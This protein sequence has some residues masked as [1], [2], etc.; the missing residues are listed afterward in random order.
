MHWPGQYVFACHLTNMAFK[1]ILVRPAGKYGQGSSIFALFFSTRLVGGFV[2]E[3][4]VTMQLSPA[5]KHCSQVIEPLIVMCACNQR[6]TTLVL[7]QSTAVCSE[8]Q[9]F[10]EAGVSDHKTPWTESYYLGSPGHMKTL[11]FCV[12]VRV[13][14]RACVSVCVRTRVR[15]CFKQLD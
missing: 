14:V 4:A 1:H 10:T 9:L 11:C 8:Q 12:S 15:L 3:F 6:K 2:Q 7:R 5:L 13:C